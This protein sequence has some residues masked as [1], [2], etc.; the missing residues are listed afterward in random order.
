MRIISVIYQQS[1][2]LWRVF[3]TCQI[4]CF[5]LIVP[6]LLDLLDDLNHKRNPLITITKISLN[7]VTIIFGETALNL[8]L[9]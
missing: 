5:T 1:N 3:C 8:S 4:S 9:S 6:D 2:D 7:H